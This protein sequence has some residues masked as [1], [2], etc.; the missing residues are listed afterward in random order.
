MFLILDSPNFHAFIHHVSI[1]VHFPIGN[2]GW[3][4]C[5]ESSI[6]MNIKS[7]HGYNHMINEDLCKAS[8]MFAEIHILLT[9]DLPNI[10]LHKDASWSIV[11]GYGKYFL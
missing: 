2:R 5:W 9:M 6:E 1:L 8:W 3:M 7:M 11:C 4:L 10:F